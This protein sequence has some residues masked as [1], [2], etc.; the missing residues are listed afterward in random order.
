MRGT[1]SVN[2]KSEIKSGYKIIRYRIGKTSTNNSLK[3]WV[4][5]MFNSDILILNDTDSMGVISRE[6]SSGHPRYGIYMAI[7]ERKKYFA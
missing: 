7:D 5:F 2:Q 6:N 1:V 3:T 4:R